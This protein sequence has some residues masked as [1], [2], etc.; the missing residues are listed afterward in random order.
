MNCTSPAEVNIEA[1]NAMLGSLFGSETTRRDAGSIRVGQQTIK[2]VQDKAANQ[3][4]QTTPRLPGASGGVGGGGETL[5]ADATALPEEV[6]AAV[7]R[8]RKDGGEAADWCVVGYDDSKQPALRVVAEG[9][10]SAEGVQEHLK[11]TELLFALVRVKQQI[12]ASATIKFVLVSWVGGE[13]AP[14]RKAKLSTLRGA[15]TSALGPFHAEL[16]N[17]SEPAAVTS[18]AL[19]ALL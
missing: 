3:A 7:G 10:G 17:P 19:L 6:A 13:V 12:D 4:A 14:M 11:D 15:T 9:A 2:V 16:L 18:A 1:I 8:V 5:R